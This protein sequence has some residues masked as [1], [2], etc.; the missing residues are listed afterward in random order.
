MPSIHRTLAL[1]A[2]AGASL[3]NAQL[4]GAS[5]HHKR[6]AHSRATDSGCP[7]VEA[8]FPVELVAAQ[9]KNV[10]THSWEYGTAA[11]A[12]LE[13]CMFSPSCS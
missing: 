8:G 6:V 10:S 9:A 4:G 3:A 2:I 13:L 11:E 12:L 5:R 1:G 7:H